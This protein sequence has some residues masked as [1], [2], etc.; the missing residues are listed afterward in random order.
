MGCGSSAPIKEARVSALSTIDLLGDPVGAAAVVFL[1]FLVVLL[2]TPAPGG[3]GEVFFDF[4]FLGG[5]FSEGLGALVGPGK[6]C[7]RGRRL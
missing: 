1:R 4:R 3:E 7:F 6:F 2:Q 5:C